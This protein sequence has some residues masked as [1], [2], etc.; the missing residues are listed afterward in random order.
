M[1]KQINEHI[2]TLGTLTIVT[3]HFQ[4]IQH[5]IEVVFV[6]LPQNTL[7]S[8]SVVIPT[9]AYDNKGLAHT[10]EHLVFCGSERHPSKGYLDLVANN[11]FSNGTNAYT[12]ENHTCYT[13]STCCLEGLEKILPIFLDH[14]F[15][16]TLNL[17]HFYT[18]VCHINRDSEFG[19]VV[20]CEMK[21]REHSEGDLCELALRQLLYGVNSPYAMECGGKTEDISRLKLDEII[22]FHQQFYHPSN[23]AILLVGNFANVDKL[24]DVIGVYLDSV[25]FSETPVPLEKVKFCS[26]SEAKHECKNVLFPSQEES[27]G[28]VSYGWR[29]PD[30]WNIE[31]INSLDLLFRYWNENSTSVLQR[32][33]VE[34][35]NPLASSV[36][37]EIYS[38][39][40]TSVSLYFSGIP[41][42]SQSFDQV[43]Q[44]LE[45]LILNFEKYFQFGEFLKFLDRFSQKLLFSFESASIDFSNQLIIPQILLGK[46]KK[47]EIE[48][49][50]EGE[51]ELKKEKNRNVSSAEIQHNNIPSSHTLTIGTNFDII[52]LIEKLKTKD[53]HFFIVTFKK[54]ITTSYCQVRMI[55]SEEENRKIQFQS[56]LLLKQ[57]I[58]CRTADEMK[59]IND[60]LERP[61]IKTT[62][63]TAEL[64]NFHLESVKFPK[65][66]NFYDSFFGQIQ[67]VSVNSE[68]FQ[69]SLCIPLNNLSLTHKKNL[70]LFQELFFQSSISNAKYNT[71]DLFEERNP[72]SKYKDGQRI[73][74]F[75]FDEFCEDNFSILS[76]DVVVKLLSEKLL[77]FS[78]SVGMDNDTFSCSYLSGYFV[79]SASCIKKNISFLF[80]MI[81]QILIGIEFTSKKVS[82]T[83]SN[84]LNDLVELKREPEEIL[85]FL[86]TRIFNQNN[87]VDNLS[88]NNNEVF[89][90][91]FAQE[92]HLQ[93]ARKEITT[94]I[95]NLKDLK[96]SILKN[97]QEFNCILQISTPNGIKSDIA[98]DFVSS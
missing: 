57:S 92:K 48:P 27:I 22:S 9:Y 21:A 88:N 79:I 11:C 30:I 53:E 4:H 83:T 78:A 62:L 97:C 76:Q 28:S 98:N 46:Y 15:F 40:P 18:E 12:A 84:L 87:Y 1:W 74:D 3:Q 20:F 68:F 47:S 58:N 81:L 77:S 96:R 42:N 67:T 24:L 23:A 73:E 13:F 66:A 52:E 25:K 95:D 5:K 80:R 7:F 56:D 45:N 33:F 89:L 63:E 39:F 71:Q 72:V 41:N 14:I 60:L 32:T 17:E 55:P 19:G 65:T 10:L 54:F 64:A 37:Y 86:T 43:Q 85:D 91:L 59:E 69:F 70:V 26:L 31:E 51:N 93:S 34:L 36:D 94:T 16:P 75:S 61:C 2:S 44:K 8:S 6:N 50:N 49:Q 90:G 82:T 38:F 35:E 29:G